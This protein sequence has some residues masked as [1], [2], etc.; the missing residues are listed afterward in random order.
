MAYRAM[1]PVAASA[2]LAACSQPGALNVPSAAES[3]S[4][5]SMAPM[6]EPEARQRLADQG[7]S[8]VRHLQR[9]DGGWTCTAVLNGKHRWR[10][11]D[12]D[13]SIH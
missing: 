12:P 8:N 5:T 4:G 3:P 13:G 1:I 7:Y 2:V 11:V 6:T 10:S 9:A